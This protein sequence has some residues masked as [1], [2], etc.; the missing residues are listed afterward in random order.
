[1]FQYQFMQNALVASLII[2]ILS[3]GIGIF[4]VLRR[5]A[6]IGDTLSHASLAGV[7]LGLLTGHNPVLTAFLFTAVSGALIEY[8]RLTFRR[9]SELILAVVL[10]LGVGTAITVISSGQ[11]SV[12]AEQ[13]LFGSILT[14]SRLDL[15]IIIGLAVI[16]FLMLG[17]LYNQLIYITYDADAAKIAGV[18]VRLINYAFSVLVASVISMMIRIVGVMVIGSMLTLPVAAAMQLGKGFRKTLFWSVIFSLIELILGLILSFYLNIAPGGF[19]ALL[20]V[21]VL[22]IVMAV[23]RVQTALARYR[24]RSTP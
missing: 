15:Y 12:N 8:L 2:G 13:F 23:M 18:R 4:L 6:M 3:P 10:A 17:F 11:L 20:A 1:M 21:A 19:T 22:L 5:Q 14:V 9:Y 24:A 7:T 16:S